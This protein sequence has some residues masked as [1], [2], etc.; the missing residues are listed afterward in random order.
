MRMRRVAGRLQF[1]CA[2]CVAALAQVLPLL[3]QPCWRWLP[4]AHRHC[5]SRRWL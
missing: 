2:V 4:P 5:Q 3:L 1:G